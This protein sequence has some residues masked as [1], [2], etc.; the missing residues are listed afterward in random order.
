MYYISDYSSVTILKALTNMGH[1]VIIDLDVRKEILHH[2]KAVLY[3]I[4]KEGYETIDTEYYVT[5]L[6]INIG[7]PRLV[8]LFYVL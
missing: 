2:R 3:D 4:S 5:V 1:V 6:N 8:V 7:D